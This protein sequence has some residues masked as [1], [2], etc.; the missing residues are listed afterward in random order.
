MVVVKGGGEGG[1]D[2]I[3]VGEHKIK[4]QFLARI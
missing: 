2:E 3:G 4:I 1:R